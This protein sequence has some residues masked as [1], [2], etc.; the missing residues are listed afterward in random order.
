MSDDVV[1]SEGDPLNIADAVCA[2]LPRLAADVRV[3]RTFYRPG[4]P[5]VVVKAEVSYVLGLLSRRRIR[6][7][8]VELAD[9]SGDSLRSSLGFG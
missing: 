5:P 2:E 9:G 1:S 4:T 6:T 3:L 7:T 8:V